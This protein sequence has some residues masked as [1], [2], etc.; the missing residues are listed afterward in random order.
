MTAVSICPY[1]VLRYQMELWNTR[2]RFADIDLSCYLLHVIMRVSVCNV[3][4]QNFFVILLLLLLAMLF[5]L[6]AQSESLLDCLGLLQKSTGYRSISLQ[7]TWRRGIDTC[8]IFQILKHASIPILSCK[9]FCICTVEDFL[10]T[11]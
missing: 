10:S 5:S 9:T 3:V 6:M 11:G 4:G 2:F 8:R 7:E 1:T